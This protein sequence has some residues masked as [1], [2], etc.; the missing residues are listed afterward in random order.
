MLHELTY[1]KP[2]FI[3]QMKELVDLEEKI[4]KYKGRMLPDDLLLRAK[5]DGFAD[6]Y[7]AKLLAIPEAEIRL[8]RKAWALSR[9]GSRSRQRGSESGL[10]LFNL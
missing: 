6:K 3:E 4:L 9:Y 2:W 1:I 5:R 8:A 7:L 10:L